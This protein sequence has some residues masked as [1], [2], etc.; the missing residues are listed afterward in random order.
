MTRKDNNRS[1]KMGDATVVMGA[2][3]VNLRSNGGIAVGKKKPQ[4]SIELL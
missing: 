3:D 1:I 4:V 2:G